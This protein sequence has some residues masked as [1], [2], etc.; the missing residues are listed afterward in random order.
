MEVAQSNLART[1]PLAQ[2]NALSQKDLDDATG[3]AEQTAA[4][5]DQAKAQLDTAQLNL[6]YTTIRSPVDGVSSYA[7]V[8]DGTYLNPQN[9][10]LT[11][12]S[13]LTPMWINFSV[14]ENELERIRNEVKRICSLPEN[15]D[16]WSRSSSSTARSFPQGQDP[17]MT[18]RTAR[19]P[20]LPDPRRRQS[21]RR[22][23]FPVCAH[24]PHRRGSSNAILVPQRAVAA[25]REGHY[26]WV[27]SKENQVEPRPSPSATG[28]AM[29]GSSRR[30]RARA[31]SSL[32]DG[33][34]RLAPGAQVKATPVPKPG[35]PA[36]AGD[37]PASASLVVNF[38]SNK[39]VLDAERCGCSR[40][41]RRR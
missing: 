32:V 8:A 29:T 18:H 33:T 6:S 13:V 41:S 19:R 23:K 9:A 31:T 12:V 27:V 2:Q 36:R 24:A 25:G 30:A 28:R 3:Q 26:V 11:T 15:K 34:L 39:A 22:M 7:A 35:R 16:F 21:R 1:K 17:F 20:Y 14:S 4:A 38:A 40:D 37:A 10:Q 5:V